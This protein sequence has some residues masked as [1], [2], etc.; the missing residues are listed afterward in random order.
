M[1]LD[2]E[3]PAGTEYEASFSLPNPIDIN[4]VQTR[5]R[6][7]WCEPLEAGRQY[8]AGFEF[9]GDDFVRTAAISDFMMSQPENEPYETERRR[10]ARMTVK[11]ETATEA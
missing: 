10:S 6:V 2:H 7:V 4:L 1:V 5:C 8:K 3:P 9:L 11:P